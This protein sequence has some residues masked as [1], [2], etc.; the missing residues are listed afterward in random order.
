MG[1]DRVIFWG[2][3]ICI[4][5]SCLARNESLKCIHLIIGFFVYVVGCLTVLDRVL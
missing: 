5:E 2:V 3:W 4:Q 1:E